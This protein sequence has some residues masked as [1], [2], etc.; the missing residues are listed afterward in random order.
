MDHVDNALVVHEHEASGSDGLEQLG[1]HPP[2]EPRHSLLVDDL[3]PDLEDPA[4][5]V[6]VPGLGLHHLQGVGEDGGQDC[7]QAAQDEG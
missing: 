6:A 5:V 3:G 1:V 2:V 7:G 4:L